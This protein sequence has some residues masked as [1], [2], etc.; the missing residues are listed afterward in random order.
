MIS[1]QLYPILFPT[2]ILY[3]P[4][5]FI[6]L[7]GRECTQIILRREFFLPCTLRQQELCKLILC[8]RLMFEDFQAMQALG[9]NILTFPTD[10][11]EETYFLPHNLASTFT[12]DYFTK[13]F[14]SQILIQITQT[15]TIADYVYIIKRIHSQF[16]FYI[17]FA[18]FIQCFGI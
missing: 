16:I 15:D 12:Q 2:R 1:L 5:S 14:F 4:I 11:I 10:Q 9:K 3:Q 6:Y 13:F 7:I 8:G 17:G 18:Q